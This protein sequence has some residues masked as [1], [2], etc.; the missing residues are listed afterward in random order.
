[1]FNHLVYFQYGSFFHFAKVVAVPKDRLEL[2][3]SLSSQGN[4]RDME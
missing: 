1:M 4:I 2:T 3:D